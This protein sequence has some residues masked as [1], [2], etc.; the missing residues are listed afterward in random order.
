M[1]KLTFLLMTEISDIRLFKVLVPLGVHNTI[2]ITEKNI[3]RT[4]NWHAKHSK[5]V[6]QRDKH[7]FCGTEHIKFT[8]KTGGFD[9]ILSF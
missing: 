8:P 4:I 9:S 3:G 5:L 6:L 7:I 2:M 1:K